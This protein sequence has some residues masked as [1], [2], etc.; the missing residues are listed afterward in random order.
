LAT[1]IKDTL[2][3]TAECEKIVADASESDLQ[4]S[5][6]LDEIIRENF[7][8]KTRNRL[9]Y[10]VLEYVWKCVQVL[11]GDHRS[12]L[13]EEDLVAMLRLLDGLS[14]DNATPY[15]EAR[16]LPH[17]KPDFTAVLL[18]ICDQTDNVRIIKL[19]AT[20]LSNAPGAR[21]RP[22]VEALG[23]AG[24]EQLNRVLV[25]FAV[26][27]EAGDQLLQAASKQGGQDLKKILDQVKKSFNLRLH[28]EPDRPQRKPKKEQE[29][30]EALDSEKEGSIEDE[31]VETNSGHDVLADCMQA[32]QASTSASGSDGSDKAKQ[33]QARA[34]SKIEIR[35]ESGIDSFLQEQTQAILDA[36]K[37]D[38]QDAKMEID[39]GNA[40]ED[41]EH[42]VKLRDIAEK[43][44]EQKFEEKYQEEVKTAAT[45]ST[46]KTLAKFKTMYADY[47]KDSISFIEANLI[48]SKF[49][50]DDSSF[51]LAVECSIQC[52][53]RLIQKLD[54]F[55]SRRDERPPGARSVAPI[56]RVFCDRVQNFVTQKLARN[57]ITLVSSSS[58]AAESELPRYISSCVAQLQVLKQYLRKVKDAE[59][60]P[61]LASSRVLQELVVKSVGDAKPFLL[62]VLNQI[63]SIDV[64]NENGEAVLKFDSSQEDAD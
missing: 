24:A 33:K 13:S 39:E 11:I 30:T 12:C 53:K 17:F 46:P 26:F 23:L 51:W 32:Q 63:S 28:L 44:F 41:E 48:Y 6:D 45:G 3:E 34:S 47:V 1:L 61:G 20:V 16:T 27:A 40:K 38:G 31:S 21:A 7:L 5:T 8:R 43:I 36:K 58:T 57:C 54:H 19:V 49:I 62:D 37:K 25:K 55:N 60:G 29:S 35:F 50:S 42:K 15:D 59:A 2:L 56:S 18:E 14:W 64:V 22:S 9:H 4:A 52:Q 10:K